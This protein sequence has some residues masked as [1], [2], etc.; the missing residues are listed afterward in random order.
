[1]NPGPNT[2]G[3]IGLG[4]YRVS[5]NPLGMTKRVNG[6]TLDW[7]QF[8][9]ATAGRNAKQTL[10]VTA[11]AGNITLTLG[12]Q[13]T[14]NIAYNADAPTIEAALELL[15]TIGNG[16]VRVSGT[17]PFTIEFVEDMG[18]QVVATLTPSA[19]ATVVS[20]Q[21]GVPD[22]DLTLAGGVTANLGTRYAAAG[23][24]LVRMNSGL[25][26]PWKTGDT[27]VRGSCYI[28]DRHAFEALD[29]AQIGDVFD[30]GTVYL[31]RML[32]GG[33]GQPTETDFLAAFPAVRVLRD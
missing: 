4:N 31:S 11:G 28:L 23:T 9:R 18:K 21:G 22:G 29:F 6:L 3:Q 26:R 20:A 30:E 19:G 12:G 32:V 16:N 25:Y 5:A 14:A 33:T 10:T 7:T 2:I 13:V 15:S 17:G 24:V 8:P 1:M 27:L